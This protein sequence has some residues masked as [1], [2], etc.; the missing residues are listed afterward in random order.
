M[1]ICASIQSSKNQQTFL[2]TNGPKS[3]STTTTKVINSID[4]KLQEY[5]QPIKARH[6]LSDQ[7]PNNTNYFLCNSEDMF[8]NCHVPHVPEDEDLQLGQIYFLMPVSKS[9][10]PIS[11]QELCVLAIKASLALKKNEEITKRT[12]SFSGLRKRNGKLVKR[13]SNE[14][15]DFQLAL[16]K[17]A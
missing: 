3:S 9:L 8:V 16:K 7:L 6:V 13:S 15:V 17:L 5:R 2:I 14:R 11:L 10:K 1:G 12:T 4:G